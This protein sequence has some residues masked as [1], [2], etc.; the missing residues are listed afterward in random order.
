MIYAKSIYTFRDHN[1]KVYGYRIQDSAGYEM[2]VNPDDLKDAI[3]KQKISIMN[4]TLTSDNRLIENK[5]SKTLQSN[6]SNI[7]KKQIDE[8]YNEACAKAYEIIKK[9]S[10]RILY[11]MGEPYNIENIPFKELLS[12][13]Y[14]KMHGTIKMHSLGYGPNG[15][16]NDLMIAVALNQTKAY[17]VISLIEK[18][19]T[20][21]RDP[22][23]LELSRPLDTEG[24][25]SKIKYLTEDYADFLIRLRSSYIQSQQT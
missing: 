8:D 1:G 4:L 17:F 14:G 3:R 20:V 18:N 2:N 10:A 5:G 21:T 24:N 22:R 25:L 13:G 15:P 11:L 12:T 7:F 19:T 9:Q 16:L 23:T 6:G